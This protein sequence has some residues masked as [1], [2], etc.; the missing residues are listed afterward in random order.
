M[1]C[2]YCSHPFTHHERYDAYYC[3]KCNYWK[4]EKCPDKECEFCNRR[5]EKPLRPKNVKNPILDDPCQ[6]WVTL[7]GDD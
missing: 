1:T 4:E 5:P 3:A 7:E 2:L 6:G